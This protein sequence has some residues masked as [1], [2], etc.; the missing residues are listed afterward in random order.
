M[1]RRLVAP[2]LIA[3]GLALALPGSATAQSGSGALDSVLGVPCLPGESGIRVCTGSLA[4]RVPSWDGVPLDV[5][6]YLPEDDG[7]PDPLI[8]GLHGFG[9]TKLGTF[10]GDSYPIDRA[11]EGY[12]VIAYSARGQGF[13]CGSS[14]R[15]PGLRA[16]AGSTSPTRATRAATPSTWPACW[17]TRDS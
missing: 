17:S 4:A 1:P 7:K 13:S 6:L 10:A 11:R 9:V 12:A 5:D 2:F 15:A 3:L 8:V 14:C 16:R